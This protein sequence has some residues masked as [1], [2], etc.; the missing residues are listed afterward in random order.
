MPRIF[1][2][3]FASLAFAAL[4]LVSVGVARADTTLLQDNFNAETPQLNK[5]DFANFNV[6]NGSVDVIGF[7]GMGKVVDIDGSS[8]NA[9]RLESKSLFTL[10]AGNTYELSFALFPNGTNNSITVMLGTAYNETFTSAQLIALGGNNFTAITRT[11]TVLSTTS[12]R[13]SFED[14]LGMDNVGILLDNVSL[15]GRDGTTPTPPPSAVPEPTTMLL[16]GTGLAGIAAKVR[17][18]RHA[19]M[20]D[21][22]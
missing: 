16:L 14:I 10:T 1:K 20:R 13:L 8:G 21:E 18:R 12:A 19:K 6:S 15:I 22:V 4:C 9:G 5:T 3:T 11:I 17:K 7:S 2:L